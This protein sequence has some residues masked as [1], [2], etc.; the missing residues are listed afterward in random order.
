VGG[1]IE[2]VQVSWHRDEAHLFVNEDGLRFKLPVN[3]FASAIYQIHFG[4]ETPPFPELAHI[5]VPEGSVIVGNAL[6]WLGPLPASETQ[7]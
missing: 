6:L 4:I 2:H 7:A 1:F 3:P 5:L